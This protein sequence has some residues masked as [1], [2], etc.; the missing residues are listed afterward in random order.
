MNMTP[1]VRGVPI[2]RS[3]M[4]ASKYKLAICGIFGTNEK[5]V[6]FKKLLARFGAYLASRQ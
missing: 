6:K 3:E 2:G 1:L 5:N 4:E